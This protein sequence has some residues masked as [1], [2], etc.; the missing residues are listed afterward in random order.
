MAARETSCRWTLITKTPAN[1]DTLWSKVR[2]VL[3]RER[4]RDTRDA[5]REEGK[6]R[7]KINNACYVGW[8]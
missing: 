5:R 8:V 3:G 2:R 6:D 1:H 4:A 7:K